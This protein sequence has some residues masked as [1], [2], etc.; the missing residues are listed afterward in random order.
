MFVR[1][2][3]AAALAVLAVA[4]VVDGNR[5][6]AQEKAFQIVGAGYGPVGLPLPGQDPRPH[7]AIGEATHLGRYYG[8]GSV[9]T[10][11]ADFNPDNGHFTGT[12]ESGEP[13]VFEAANG[14]ILACD[15]GHV[16]D[17]PGTFEL[18]PTGDPGVYVAYWV[19][20]F[21]PVDSL[22]T[23]KFKGITGSWTMYAQSEPFVLGSDDP[24]A[25]SWEGRGTL[26]FAK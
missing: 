13:F 23:G 22:C 17:H 16:A 20:E 3:L 26:T 25:Y 8:E 5:V 1:N 2:P 18:V 9:R 11:T 10:L 6:R 7:W 24:I 15:Y 21:V 4:L 12:F 14:D 19:A